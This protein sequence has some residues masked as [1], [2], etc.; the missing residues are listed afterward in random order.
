MPP[1]STDKANWNP[2]CHLER[3]VHWMLI[4]GVGMIVMLLLWVSLSWVTTWWTNH[5]LDAT[6]G[7]PRTF[8]TDAVVGH[9]DSPDHRSHFLFLNLSGHVLII[10]IP[11]GDAS[12]S[13]IYSGP[14]LFSD[15]ADQVPI[16]GE[17]KDVNGDG[18]IDMIVHI[19]DKTII[20]LNDGTQF[21]PQ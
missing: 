4:L 14:T 9:N 13:R 11:G 18:K 7:Y 8:Q 21:K 10:E 2:K 16:T 5:Q 6:Y 17:F 20:Y 15:N 1:A 19:A 3:K 12:K